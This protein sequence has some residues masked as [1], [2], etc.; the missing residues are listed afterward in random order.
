[1]DPGCTFTPVTDS[2][3]DDASV[4]SVVPLAVVTTMLPFG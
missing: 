2:G 3:P 1:V 4:G